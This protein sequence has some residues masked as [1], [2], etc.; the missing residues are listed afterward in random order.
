MKCHACNKGILSQKAKQQT[1]TYKDKF[2]TLE[3]PGLWCDFCDEGILSGDDIAK[4]EK[5]FDE[6]KS[7]V[8]GLLLPEEIRRIRKDV[9]HLS[10]EEAGRIFGGGKNGFSRYERGE[11]RPM[12]AVS[13]LLKLLERHPEDLK[14]FVDNQKTA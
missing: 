9:L 7:K 4:T 14:Y 8:D 13:N 10:Q 1:Y 5:A 12:L 11:I 6:F 2:I 3:Q